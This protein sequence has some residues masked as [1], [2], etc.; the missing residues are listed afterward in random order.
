MTFIEL[1]RRL[2][3]NPEGPELLIALVDEIR[4]HDASRPETAI[5]ALASLSLHLRHYPADVAKLR[6]HVLDLL[7]TRRHVHLYTETGILIHGG[8]F[9]TLWQRFTTGL[10]P[11]ERR[12][13]YLKDLFGLI[14]HRK[15]DHVWVEAI[16]DATWGELLA[17][18]NFAAEPHPA[19]DHIKRELLEAAQVLSY[20]IAALGLDPELTRVDPA[21]E[22]FESPFMAQSAE[23]HRAMAV[24]R[25]LRIEDT[26][27]LDDGHALVL[28]D[29]CAEV[30]D[31]IR[32]Q[33]RSTGA[34]ISL[35][36]HLQRGRQMIDR[37]KAVLA[38][39]N[40]ANATERRTVALE[41]LRELVLED[42]RKYSLRDVSRRA[43]DLLALQV[44]E[45]A[46]K[47]GEHYAAATRPEYFAMLRS[48]AG[49]G[50]IVGFMALIKI[51][52]GKVTMAPIMHAI[53]NSM[54]YSFGF[55]LIHVL[56]FTVATKQPAMT[57]ATIAATVEESTEK[58]RA[59]LDGV[60]ELIAVVLRTQFLAIMGNVMLALPVSFIIALTLLH[61]H[62]MSPVSAEKAGHLLHDINPFT[63]LALFHAAIAGVCLFLAGLISGYYDNKSTYNRIPQR[64]KQLRWLRLVFGE[65]RQARLADYIGDNLGALAGNFFFGI[66]L[67]SM[68]TIG[69]ITGLPIDIRHVTFSAANLAYA[70]VGFDFQ[71]PVTTL[72]VSFLGVMLVGL[73][74]LAVSFSLALSV[75]MKSRGVRF[76]RSGE[77]LAL[78]ARRFLARPRDF[79]LPPPKVV[80]AL[81]QQQ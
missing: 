5:A 54:N 64:I 8:F 41:L 34:S 63:S 79:F 69:W 14:F 59:P 7:A 30:L 31:R 36:Y 80:P 32:R 21:I 12:D 44:T 81:S 26:T 1:L 11:E 73:T 57:A 66:M 65:Q 62:G 52:M 27:E 2:D 15:T 16:P 78:V 18:I 19:H 55:M 4:P 20:R 46:S 43:T 3:T 50:F 61:W 51:F 22:E 6:K 39:A 71:V 38:L 23:L 33:S 72:L 13:D 37:L 25:D 35:T 24:F 47:T 17:A 49:A 68:G 67:G 9:S 29:Q 60:V 74:N 10:L 56:H 28:L 70:T 42:N 40:P 77:L 58:K 48:A 45:N 53:T 75:A 76:D